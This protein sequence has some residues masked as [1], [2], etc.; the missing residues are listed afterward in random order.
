MFDPLEIRLAGVHSIDASA[1]TGK[2]WTITTLYLRY[3]LEGQCRIDQILVTT[4]TDAATAELRDR[5]R[6]RLVSA[7]NLIRQVES[8][9]DALELVRRNE[10]DGQVLQLL[11]R[12]GAW[13]EES[14]IQTAERLEDAL[15]SFDQA[16]IF[17]IHGFCSRVLTELVFETGSR[18]GMELVSSLTDLVDDA[19]ADFVARQWAIDETPLPRWLPL[20][21]NRQQRML[22]VVRQA[23]EHPGVAIVPDH[24][25]FEELM[26]APELKRFEDSVEEL[27]G[28][29]PQVRGP[30][31]EQ[32][33][34]ACDRKWFN[35]KRFRAD[36]YGGS[37]EFVDALARDRSPSLLRWDSEKDRLEPAQARLTESF[38]RDALKPEFHSQFPWHPVFQIIERVTQDAEQLS[39][40]LSRL[41]GLLAARAATVVRSDVER[42]KRE[43]GVMSF[44]DLLHQLDAALSGRPNE[45]LLSSLRE[46][47]RVAL[48]DEFQD[49]DPVQFRIFRRIFLEAAQTASSSA[50]EPPRS[51][52]MIGDPKQSIYHF[53]GAD[54]DSY[55]EAVSATPP[56]QRHQMETNWRSDR[57]LVQAVQAVFERSNDPFRHPLIRIPP[58]A[59][60]YADRLSG[61]PALS[62]TVVPRLNERADSRPPTRDEAE[63]AVFEQVV[64]DVVHQLQSRSLRLHEKSIDQSPARPLQPSDIAILCRTGAQLR[65]IQKRLSDAGVPGV[66]ISDESVLTSDEA[67][68]VRAVL[69]AVE[70]PGQSALVLTALQ[71][72]VFGRAAS[73]LFELKQDADRLA[74]MMDH[75]HRWHDLWQRDGFIVMWKQLLDDSET[76]ARLAGSATGARTITNL[77]HIGELLHRRAVESHAGPDELLRWFDRARSD[78]TVVQDDQLLRLET[79]ADAVQLSTIHRSKGLEYSIVYCPTLWSSRAADDRPAGLLSRSGEQPGEWLDLPELDTGSPLMSKRIE[80]EQQSQRAEEHRLLYVALTRARHQC[81]LY[82]TACSSPWNTALGR[83]IHEA[84]GLPADTPD[85]NDEEMEQ[86]VR[87]WA[88]ALAAPRVELAGARE[89]ASQP[90]A[91]R[92]VPAAAT[93]VE[94]QCHLVERVHLPALIQTSFTQLSHSGSESPQ[95]DTGDIEDHDQTAWVNADETLRE[96]GATDSSARIDVPESPALPRPALKPADSPPDIPETGAA[97]RSRRKTSAPARSL[98]DWVPPSKEREPSSTSAG[99]ELPDSLVPLAAMPG[100]A[101]VGDFVHRILEGVMNQRSRLRA[102]PGRVRDVLRR[103]VNHG[104]IRTQLDSIWLDPLTDALLRTLTVPCSRREFSGRLLDL[105]DD[106]AACEVPFQLRLGRRGAG[107]HLDDLAAV[108]R[109]SP[110]PLMQDASDRIRRMSIPGAQGLLA[111]VIDLIFEWQGRW[112]ILDYKTNHL[113]PHVADYSSDPVAAAMRD[114]DYVL[115]YSLYAV[116]LRLF[117]QQ[118]L[119]DFD[120]ERQFGGVLYYFLRGFNSDEQ[121][122]TGVFFDRPAPALIDELSRVITQQ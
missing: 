85:L 15:L 122:T 96:A 97:S 35:G 29:W 42:R 103:E 54:L 114:H 73:Q 84:S 2:T 22:S 100:G 108:F 117:L 102:E 48:V 59:A 118:R 49:T 90:P 47:Y 43:L 105:P 38:L 16:P 1:G 81:R 74:A 89:L 9:A 51:F 91:R 104:L 66:L 87:R 99:S 36:W 30:I 111:G 8:E 52:V 95:A 44:G 50:N 70:H 79:D 34:A 68:A 11:A 112:F 63:Q 98:L 25:G 93:A 41:D 94:L 77:L 119:P 5:L 40:I 75:F 53:R 39:D 110:L 109:S 20:N 45:M 82:W 107:F 78:K 72:P 58:V 6:R 69:Q 80:H 120:F 23:V 14:R 26:Q 3:L 28:I 24:H 76:V 71:T 31:R 83:F 10:G 121:L 64:R 92:Y 7:Q 19:L 13:R 67:T 17:T 61:G 27:A 113:G 46:R 18:F 101:G 32:I 106:R 56:E 4:F 65:L 55:L 12:A 62:I 37:E 115:Q 86:V 88:E 57:S 33:L 21:N 60:H 116:A